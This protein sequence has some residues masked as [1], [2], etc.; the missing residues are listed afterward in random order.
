MRMKLCL[1]L[2]A[3]SIFGASAA[4]GQDAAGTTDAPKGSGTSTVPQAAPA[5]KPMR[6][7]IGGRIAAANITHMV[8]PVYPQSAKD[9]GVS[10]TV[11]LHCI[12]A[13]DGT[14][15]QVEY[16]SG[17]PL[18]MKAA[19]DAVRQWTYK[20][21]TLN[22]KVIEVDT[23][24]SV[25]FQLGKKSSADAGQSV[26]GPGQTGDAATPS[27]ASTEAPT[28]KP[29]DP[30][31]KA[32]ILHLMNVTHFKEK[33]DSGMRSVLDTMRPAMLA[34]IP[35]TPNREKILNSY[36]DKLVGLIES[37]N[38]TDAVTE[39]YAKYL[40][41]A[42]VKAASAFYETPAGQHYLE[43]TEKLMPEAMATGQRIASE[44]IPTILKDL[45]KEYPELEG[46]AKFCGA[47]DPTKKSLLPGEHA[48][49][50][51]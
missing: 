2:L 28:P 18:L 4:F 6:A 38:F 23:T 22:G 10:G 35:N 27:A 51:N 40:T 37:E 13:K 31:L 39:L 32:D 48:P 3:L 8:Q 9:A 5:D 41:D 44:N 7:R 12:I 46:E 42:D 20:P 30:Q 43:S 50:G 15:S 17:P 21:T 45:C 49:A 26:A 16:V 29:V 47:P 33:Q 34:G 1:A 25:V 19:I 24:V 36:I 14:M 11:V